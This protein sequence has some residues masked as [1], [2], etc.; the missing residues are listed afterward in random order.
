M[1]KQQECNLDTDLRLFEY[2][3]YVSG[4]E[5]HPSANFQSYHFHVPYYLAL[6]Q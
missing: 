4:K 1:T 5:Y 3:I 2:R 6:F